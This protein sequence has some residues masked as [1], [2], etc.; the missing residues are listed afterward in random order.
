MVERASP[1][2]GATPRQPRKG[3]NGTS[4]VARPSVECVR[5]RPAFSSTS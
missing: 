4:H 1:F 5:N 2:P 3:R